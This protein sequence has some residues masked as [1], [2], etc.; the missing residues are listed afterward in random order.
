MKKIIIILIL[1]NIICT[2]KVIGCDLNCDINID[3]LFR[4]NFMQLKAIVN[5]SS[6]YVIVEERS[7]IKFL[8]IISILSGKNFISDPHDVVV[9]SVIILAMEDWYQK[10]KK[11]IT[12]EKIKKAYTLLEPLPLKTPEEVEMYSVELEQLKI[13][14]K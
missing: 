14:D 2:T 8:Y 3:S 6:K 7:N 11:Y 5:D 9:D 10:K 12:C 4:T 13:N 1:F